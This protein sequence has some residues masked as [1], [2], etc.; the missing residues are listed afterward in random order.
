[1][2]RGNKDQFTIRSFPWFLV[3]EGRAEYHGACTKGGGAEG[4][5]ERRENRRDPSLIFSQTATTVFSS[6]PACQLSGERAG[7]F[8]R[9]R[10][11]AQNTV[12]LSLTSTRESMAGQRA[13]LLLLLVCLHLPG[14]PLSEAA[15][16]F[17]MT[18]IGECM[19]KKLRDGCLIRAQA[20]RPK[21][22]GHS[23]RFSR[24]GRFVALAGG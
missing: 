12:L 20:N 10:C 18:L 16:I 24:L 9:R 19:A 1:M 5:R 21:K 7:P 13:L 6:P 15:K 14:L 4:R 3:R 11:R 22:E 8:V 17:T 23:M 2:N